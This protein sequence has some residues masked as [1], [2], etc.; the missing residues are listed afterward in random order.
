MR[1]RTNGAIGSIAEANPKVGIL[2]HLGGGNLGDDATFAT[3]LQQVK[4]RWPGAEVIGYS[5]APAD[6]RKRHGVA[7]YP[8]RREVWD[9]TY[10][11]GLDETSEAERLK[12]TLSQ[13]PF[14]FNVI[15]SLKRAIFDPV[16]S[17][18][19]EIAFLFKASRSVR[20]LDVLIV[21]GGG[22]LLDSWGG[23]WKFPFTILKFVLLARLYGARSYVINVGA[24]P[25]N[26]VLS[27][28]FIRRALSLSEYVS[29]RDEDSRALAE[30]IGYSKAR[31]VFPD[32]VYGFEMRGPDSKSRDRDGARV[33]GIS[34]MAYKDPRRW[35]TQDE[36]A[37][38]RFITVLAQFGSGLLA[39]RSDLRIFSTDIS[40]D[41]SALK[42]FEESLRGIA[43]HSPN[44][45]SRIDTIDGVD[46]LLE[47]IAQLDYV[48]TCRFHGVIFAH[49]LQKPVLAVSHHQKVKSLMRDLGLSAYCLDIRDLSAGALKKAFDSL[50]RNEESVRIQ[51]AEKARIYRASIEQ[52]FDLL[53][54][55]SA[56][57]VSQAIESLSGQG[58]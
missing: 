16:M 46:R 34:P 7:A 31:L 43:G 1:A 54:G 33:V 35:W 55:T 19:S 27:R 50:I 45:I 52:Q 14:L 44:R 42:D 38:K 26:K 30:Q 25:L 24:G 22:Q 6:T 2:D 8:I 20:T 18:L 3:I 29:F 57:R 13:V 15:Y 12:G 36:T 56:I 32:C 53:F 21:G 51:M 9:I 58:A 10:R 49:L 47:E 39:D 48:V 23:P 40:F 37:Y 11:P 5:M 17:A 41:A 4:R 28:Y